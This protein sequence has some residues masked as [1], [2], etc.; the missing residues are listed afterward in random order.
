MTQDGSHSA[1]AAAVAVTAVTSP[2]PGG[3]LADYVKY[4]GALGRPCA[5]TANG[6]QAW[7]PGVRGELQRFPLECTADVDPA[8]LRPLLKQPGIWLATYLLQGSDTIVPNCFDYVCRG[9]DYAIEKLATDARQNVRRGYKNFAVRLCS[10]DELAQKGY[11]ADADTAERHAY[12]KPPA[13]YLQTIVARQ[14]GSPFHEVWG[15]WQGEDLAAWMTAIKIDNW[16]ITD[17]VR[18]CTAAMKSRPNN[19][20][21]YTA[22]RHWLVDEKRDYV[23]YGLSSIQVN[24]HELSMHKYKT[25]MGYE[26]LPLHRKFVL[27]PL[28]RP[29]VTSALLSWGWEKLAAARPHSANLRKLAGMSRLLSGRQ[30]APLAWAEEAEGVTGDDRAPA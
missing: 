11:T 6:T 9:A 28:V 22:T 8:V 20:L 16:V 1:G 17:V 21:L 29:L 12:S 2:A 14:R 4:V 10:W 15:V 3:S 19:V 26:A 23:S 25:R 18:S 27:H 7:V 13:E 24:V 30:K 5:L